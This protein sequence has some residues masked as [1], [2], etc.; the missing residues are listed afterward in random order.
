MKKEKECEARLIEIRRL[1]IYNNQSL[2]IPI[3][4]LI[5]KKFFFF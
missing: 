5:S 3:N 2:Q 1:V 4:I